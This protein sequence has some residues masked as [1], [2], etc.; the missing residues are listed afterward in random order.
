[1]SPTVSSSVIFFFPSCFSLTRP[2]ADSTTAFLTGESGRSSFY[3]YMNFPPPSLSPSSSPDGLQKLN[4]R[5]P[6]F[7]IHPWMGQVT[8]AQRFICIFYNLP[9][10]LSMYLSHPPMDFPPHPWIFLHGV[11]NR[12][13]GYLM[14]IHGKFP[15]PFIPS[16][17][18]IYG[19][20]DSIRSHE[21]CAIYGQKLS[22]AKTRGKELEA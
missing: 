12:I 16:R 6:F 7:N 3:L 5:D 17:P 21:M 14:S 1:M 10:L 20:G 9:S 11:D 22:L 2:A 18:P 8:G 13:D 19:C 15:P 4:T